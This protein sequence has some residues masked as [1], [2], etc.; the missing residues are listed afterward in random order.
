MGTDLTAIGQR[1]KQAARQ[2][3]RAGTER[4]NT[5]LI[6]IAQGLAAQQS[7]ILAANTE[8]AA[9][10][11]IHGLDAALIDRL[12]LTPARLNSMT[13]DV[14][15][16]VDLPDPVGE[17]FDARRLPNGLHLSRRRVPIGVLGVIYEARPNVT[18]D[19][20]TLCLKT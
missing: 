10:A 11:R 1:A 19:V 3:G 5:A 15:K 9:D 7:E 12:T 13:A 16:V 14:R 4:K 6:A 2:L 8:D 20:A 17:E 18:V